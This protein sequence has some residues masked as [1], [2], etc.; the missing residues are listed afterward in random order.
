M[1]TITSRIDN[2]TGI[3]DEYRSTIIPPPRSIKIGLTE[4]CGYSCAFC[5]QAIRKMS[6]VMRRE[7]Y[8]LV[9]REAY[10][11]GIEEVGLFF[12]GESFLLSSDRLGAAVREARQMFPY[13]FLTTN[14]S[15]A[16]E[17][18]LEAVMA[19]GLDSLKFSLNFHSP[20]Q[21]A[22][23]A[24]VPESVFDQVIEN[25]KTAAM[26][27]ERGGYH[28]NLY[29][30]SIDFDGEQGEKMRGLVE[31]LK[32]YVS[33]TYRLPLYG[34]SGAAIAAGMKPRPGNPGRL[35]NLREPIPCWSVFRETRV[36]SNLDVVAC[37][38]GPGENNEFVI[39]NLREQ[40]FMAIWNGPK[41]QELRA[42]HLSGD[43]TGTAC[44]S[45]AAGS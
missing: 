24:K 25:I 10:K 38:F 15:N 7:D 41:A 27:K 16:T 32:P 37:C 13:I 26:V 2:V 34:M 20:A 35:D 40:D 1:E 19:N 4:S 42:A 8:S 21:L 18:K 29:I 43:V 9:L 28:C 12:L 6:G 30:S 14:A 3:P 36:M 22:E 5:L 39:G 45:C 33:E 11:A 31:S 17:D 44:E 23:I